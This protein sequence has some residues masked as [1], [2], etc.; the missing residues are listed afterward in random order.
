MT[1]KKGRKRKEKSVRGQPYDVATKVIM[2]K[3]ADRMLETFLGIQA[4]DIEYLE[5]LPQESASLK[6]SDYILRVIDH[7]QR[8]KIVL[9][10]FLSQ[11]RRN[12]ILSLCDYM[13]RAL[14]KY[15]L[16]VEPVVLLLTPSPQ[17]AD[18]LKDGGLQFRFTLLKLYEMPAADFLQHADLHLLPFIPIM[19]G[20][21][22]AVWE[23]E[24]AIYSGE[25]PASE[26]ADLLTALAIFAGLKDQ[27]LARQLVERRRD[28]MV[29][30]YTYEL[31]KQEGFAE[32]M[33]QGMQQ[34]MQ[35]ERKK[36]ICDVLE[37]RF[38][39]VPVSVFHEIDQLDSVQGLEELLRKAVTVKDLKSFVALIERI[40]EPV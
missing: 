33:Q 19:Q 21:E 12:A 11:W 18:M 26:R 38:E 37:E 6:R 3:A 24:K 4:V 34:G 17:A 13:V 16:P 31:I 39:V 22:Q 40:M 15:A 9:W 25:L 8:S 30:S 2:D 35:H 36:A 1:S 28:I 23:A 7:E 32:G 5:A 10:E 20:G 27:Q 14:I 29:Q